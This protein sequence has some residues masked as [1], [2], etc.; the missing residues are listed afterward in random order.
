MAEPSPLD[1]VRNR[2]V[3]LQTAAEQLRT[4][5][6]EDRP[7]D[8]RHPPNHKALADLRDAVD[9]FMDATAEAVWRAQRQ[10]GVEALPAVHRCVLRAAAVL[11]TELL[12][13]DRRFD[14]TRRAV[15][16]WGPLWRPWSRVVLTNLTE[17][18]EALREAELGLATAWAATVPVSSR[19]TETLEHDLE[20]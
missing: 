5:V 8:D 12:P 13:V 10:A 9:D 1:V 7:D 15:R 16:T 20:A 17:A 14:T 4:A 6:E 19:P 2:L 11:H 18:A 3:A